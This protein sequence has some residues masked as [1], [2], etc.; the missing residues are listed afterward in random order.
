MSGMRLEFKLST[1]DTVLRIVRYAELL[2]HSGPKS[3]KGRHV[4]ARQYRP[5]ARLNPCEH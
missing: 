1:N 4:S 3:D 2:F 5:V